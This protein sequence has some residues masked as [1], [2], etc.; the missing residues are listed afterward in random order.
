MILDELSSVVEK[1]DA[2]GVL[3]SLVV[4]AAHCKDECKYVFE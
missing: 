4:F 1:C 2:L 3:V